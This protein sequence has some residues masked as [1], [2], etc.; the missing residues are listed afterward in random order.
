MAG[1]LKDFVSLLYYSCYGAFH[2]SGDLVLAYHSVADMGQGVD[3]YKMNVPLGLF[4]A[5][6]D[7]L[8]VLKKKRN[9]I[10][11]F[12]DGFR[13][14]YENA[15]PI[16]S[17]SGIQAMLFVTTDFIDRKITFGHLFLS[18]N[19]CEPLTWSQI[20]EI[21]SLGIEIGSH[22]ITHKNLSLMDAKDA[23]RELT[24]SKKII[25]D[26][27]GK[28]VEYF[29][30]PFGSRCA[31]TDNLKKLV[32]AN[33]YVK[34]YS[35]IMGFNSD[36]SDAYALRRMRIYSTDHMPRFKMKLNGAYNWVDYAY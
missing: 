20:K 12:D 10:L 31:I 4:K 9:I 5:Q 25:E 33:G 28:P 8:G 32:A 16:V 3:K 11:T 19:G 6:I 18:G 22:A 29:A 35:N 15:L 7:Y 14:F 27:I 2:K 36:K 23:E 21:S 30:Y 24:D 1:L 17:G 34:A 13:N 26:R